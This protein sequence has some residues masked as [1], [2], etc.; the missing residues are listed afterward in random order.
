MLEGTQ[1]IVSTVLLKHSDS[2]RMALVP[3]HF[4]VLCHS[5]LPRGKMTQQGAGMGGVLLR[6]KHYSW[7]GRE[8]VAHEDFSPPCKHDLP[9]PWAGSAWAVLILLRQ[10]FLSS[11][12]TLPRTLIHRFVNSVNVPVLPCSDV[13]SYL[14]HHSRRTDSLEARTLRQSSASPVSAIG[15]LQEAMCSQA[16]RPR[17]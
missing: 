10:S 15:S 11:L 7:S 16:P 3:A 2:A 5:V 4:P 13:I 8:W 14:A 17:L 1:G 6:R 9:F 12:R